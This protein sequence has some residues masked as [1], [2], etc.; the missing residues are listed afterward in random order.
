MP[1]MDDGVPGHGGCMMMQIFH[2][3]TSGAMHSCPM[4]SKKQVGQAFE[5]HILK[6]GA[7]IGL[8]SDNAKSELHGH[9][10]DVLCLCSVDDSQFEPHCH[11]QNQAKHKMQDVKRAMNN[12]MDCVGCPACAWPLCAIFALM[13]F[14]HLPDSNGEIPLTAQTRQTPD[15]SELCTSTSGKKFHLN[16]TKRTKPKNWPTG[17]HRAHTT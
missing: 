12:M 13:L 8:K 10:K 5:D 16:C 4:K 14:C 3:L 6:I 1:A 11:H 2:G 7:P 9:T 17:V 15:I